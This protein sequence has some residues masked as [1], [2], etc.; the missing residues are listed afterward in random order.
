MSSSSGRTRKKHGK[1]SADKSHPRQSAKKSTSNSGLVDSHSDEYVVSVDESGL[2]SVWTVEHLL[3]HSPSSAGI[4]IGD[5]GSPLDLNSLF[6]TFESASRLLQCP[7]TP[8]ATY[9]LDSSPNCL[10]VFPR[11]C[12][13]RTKDDEGCSSIP[14]ND[15]PSSLSY[16]ITSSFDLSPRSLSSPSS[17]PI[18]QFSVGTTHG[19]VH[20]IT[21]VCSID[22]VSS[23]S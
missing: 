1:S 5:D 2:L 6:E 19:L 20:E 11:T 14:S 18:A 4:G 7:C 13:H 17:Q 9:S 3:S 10:L 21:L 8:V 22:S 12:G 15:L 23:D 16:S